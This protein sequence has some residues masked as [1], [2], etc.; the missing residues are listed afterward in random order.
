MATVR[1]ICPESKRSLFILD[2]G[3]KLYHRKDID[4]TLLFTLVKED[5]PG[6]YTTLTE[7]DAESELD[8]L[9]GPGSPT[10]SLSILTVN[11][12]EDWDSVWNRYG[13]GRE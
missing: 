12:I 10:H 3:V 2:S 11:E 4:K 9:E 6:T 8:P 7:A 13:D 1:K 5:P